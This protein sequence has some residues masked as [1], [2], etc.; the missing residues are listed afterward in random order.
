[1]ITPASQWLANLYNLPKDS[2]IMLGLLSTKTGTLVITQVHEQGAK[3]HS[4][5]MK[6]IPKKALR[7]QQSDT[8][9]TQRPDEF[10]FGQSQWRWFF[11]GKPTISWTATP[12][13][14]KIAPPL[15][16]L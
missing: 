6:I 14:S 11:L 9:R 13:S 3:Y 16:A 8:E 1:M 15:K 10:L 2:H 12:G 4:V 7:N 5:V